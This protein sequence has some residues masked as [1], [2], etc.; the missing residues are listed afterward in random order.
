LSN[1]H[2]CSYFISIILKFLDYVYLVESKPLLEE[3]EEGKGKKE[4]KEARPVSYS[5]SF[6]HLIFA[7]ASMYSAMLLSGWTSTSES[8]DLIDVGWTSVWVRIGTEWVT[9]GL[10][11][12]SLLAPLLFPDREFA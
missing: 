8:S 9:A 3:V 6:F 5:Y 12:W 7:L 2:V 4:E 10:Y 1:I 11:L